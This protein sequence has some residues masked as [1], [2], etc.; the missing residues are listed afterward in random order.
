MAPRDGLFA[1]APRILRC[2][3]DRRRETRRRPTWP[4]AKLSNRAC[5]CRRFESRRESFGTRRGFS[6]R[7][8]V[9]PR[10]GFEPPTNGLTVRRS[11]T[12]LPGNRKRRGLSGRRAFKSRN[13]RAIRCARSR[14]AARTGPPIARFRGLAR[15]HA[16]ALRSRAFCDGRRNSLFDAAK[17]VLQ[18]VHTARERDPNVIWCAKA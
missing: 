5:L 9:A 14:H 15:L 18:G 16:L 13:E 11:T 7:H 1:A 4:A 17:G 12:E 6:S 10:D 3:P 2:A 8:N